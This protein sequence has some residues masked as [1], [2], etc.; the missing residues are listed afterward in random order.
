MRDRNFENRSEEFWNDVS[1]EV[2]RILKSLK[3]K[4]S[5]DLQNSPDKLKKV[6]AFNN[7]QR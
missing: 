1:K 4:E 7:I 2:Y 5:R 6:V 3:H